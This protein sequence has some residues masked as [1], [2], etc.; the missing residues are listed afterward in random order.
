MYKGAD[1]RALYELFKEK[2]TKFGT[3]FRHD[4]EFIRAVRTMNF[5]NVDEYLKAINYDEKKSK[6][7]FEKKAEKVAKH[8]LPKKVEEIKVLGGG[9]DT[10]GSS[11]DRHGGFGEAPRD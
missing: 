10:T 9:Q 5:N 2:V 7:D 1:R 4:P 6:D 8:D 3:N 11:E